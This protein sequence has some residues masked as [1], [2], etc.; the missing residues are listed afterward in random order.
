MERVQRG[1][2]KV[3][4]S[5]SPDQILPL[6]MGEVGGDIQSV[7]AESL[8]DGGHGM[9]PPTGLGGSSITGSRKPP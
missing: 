7:R 2:L 5:F 8:L 1:K 4:V 6:F 9:A 3:M